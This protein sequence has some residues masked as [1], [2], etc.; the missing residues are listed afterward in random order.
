MQ[1]INKLRYFFNPDFAFGCIGC[2][3]FNYILKYKCATQGT[4]TKESLLSSKKR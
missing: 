3:K 4:K 2:L 1:G